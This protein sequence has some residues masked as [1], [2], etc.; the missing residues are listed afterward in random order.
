ML[1]PIPVITFTNLC[2]S[3]K[4]KAKFPLLGESGESDSWVSE[5]SSEDSDSVHSEEA[6]VYEQ[7]SKACAKLFEDD[8]GES[9]GEGDFEGF[10]RLM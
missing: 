2:T 6:L 3:R 5:G 9:V 10:E 4:R 8:V 7:K 1:T